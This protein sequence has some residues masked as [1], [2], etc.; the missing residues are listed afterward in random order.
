MNAALTGWSVLSPLGTTRKEFAHNVCAGRSA[1]APVENFET[2]ALDSHCA[3]QLRAAIDYKRYI[4]AGHLRRMDG[5]SRLMVYAACEAFDHAGVAARGIP[6]DRRAVVVASGMNHTESIEQFYQ[7]LLQEGPEGANP[8]HFPA[9]IPNC[10]GGLIAIELECRGPNLTVTQ[11]ETS[12]EAALVLAADLLASREADMVLVAAGEALTPVVFDGL[13]RVR[14]LCRQERGRPEVMRPFSRGRRGF[15]V[16]EG[17]AAVVLEPADKAE[18]DG[19]PIF[20]RLC[21]AAEACQNA[22]PMKYPAD[23]QP[24]LRA[25]EAMTLECGFDSASAAFISSAA[26]ATQTLDACE[27][28]IIREINKRA[29]RSGN[30]LPVAAIKAAV[31]EFCAG[32]LTRIL[33][34]LAGLQASVCP[35]LPYG[36]A[37]ADCEFEDVQLS[38]CSAPAAV[39]GTGFLHLAA[40]AGGHQMALWFRSEKP[41]IMGIEN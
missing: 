15:I 11:K 34:A 26:N 20:G 33:A 37:D 22:S 16:G 19:R 21:G 41:E 25:I 13:S 17:V 30:P 18:S 3:A 23:P 9:T 31:G 6:P 1:I 38:F 5:L 40:A 10:A 27:A 32:G 7:S 12:A 39:E 36:A 35:P 28:Q 29:G 4:P 2:S 8:I 24:L 14:A